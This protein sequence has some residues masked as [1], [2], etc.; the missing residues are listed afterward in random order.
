MLPVE[1]VVNPPFQPQVW[2][3]VEYPPTYTAQPPLPPP[4]GTRA[5]YNA[6]FSYT[7]RPTPGS[8]AG[9][10]GQAPG[11]PLAPLPPAVPAAPTPTPATGAPGGI[12]GPSIAR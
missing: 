10:P 8:Q 2:Y 3:T 7:P 11:E 12:G 1:L 6:P 4:G 5:T 9:L